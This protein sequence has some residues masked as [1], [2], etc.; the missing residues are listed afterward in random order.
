MMRRRAVLL[1]TTMTAA[2]VVASGVALA[3]TITC[4]GGLCVGTSQDD[5]MNGTNRKDTMRGRGGDDTIR[6]REQ[7]DIVLGQADN[8][9][10][11]GQEGSDKLTGGTGDDALSGGVTG[12]DAYA[13]AEGWGQDRLT[14]DFSG[15]DTLDFSTLTS[16]VRVILIASADY[17]EASD[18][19]NTLNFPSTVVIE[20]VMG[21]AGDDVIGANT[22]A[23]TDA[24]NHRFFGNGGGDLL[25]GGRGNDVLNG[26]AGADL[27]GF[28][29]GWGS[30]TIAADSSGNDSLSF[31]VVASSVSIDLEASDQRVEVL[32][33]QSTLDFPS[34]VVIENAYGGN[35]GDDIFG[36]DSGNQLVGNGGDDELRGRSGDDLLLGIDGNDTL[37]GESGSDQLHGGDGDDEIFAQDGEPDEILC[38]EDP[39]GLDN[40]VVHADP[41]SVPGGISPDTFPDDSCETID[42]AV[43]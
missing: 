21:G 9:T 10:L 30:D 23:G 36:N 1:I 41:P 14:D 15:R 40:D 22:A 20:D 42:D 35:T 28:D 25:E 31:S 2:L 6:G 29:D 33:D 4:T 43:N 27:Y 34:T 3:A 8:D 32:S 5:T 39:D 17:D 37:L 7:G 12:N 11:L 38:G 19:T 13:F 24:N 18:D 26:G 16:D